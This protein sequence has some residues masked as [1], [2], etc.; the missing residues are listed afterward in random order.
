MEKV[1]IVTFEMLVFFYYKLGTSKFLCAL[2]MAHGN[3]R[4]WPSCFW[5]LFICFGLIDYWLVEGL[6][7]RHIWITFELKW[8]RSRHIYRLGTQSG[9]LTQCRGLDWHSNG[10]IFWSSL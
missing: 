9:C 8:D 5:L 6:Y 3:L 10:A 7:V 1:V 2:N 4:S